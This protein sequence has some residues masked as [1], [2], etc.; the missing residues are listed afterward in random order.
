[1]DGYEEV[2]VVTRARFEPDAALYAF[3][4]DSYA[5]NRSYPNWRRKSRTTGELG[6]ILSDP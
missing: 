5:T 2:E 1:M 3:C 4:L 6:E